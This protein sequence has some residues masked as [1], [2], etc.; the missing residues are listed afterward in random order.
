[1]SAIVLAETKPPMGMVF[2]A[3]DLGEGAIDHLL[4][5][6]PS[7][8]REGV[9]QGWVDAVLR[10]WWTPEFLA[11]VEQGTV[12]EFSKHFRRSGNWTVLS[13]ASAYEDAESAAAALQVYL[14]DYSANWGLTEAG[15]PKLG[16][17][18]SIF[19]GPNPIGGAPMVVYVWRAGPYILHILATG[20]VEADA[21]EIRAIAEGMNDRVPWPR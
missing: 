6:S 8:V 19:E 3:E 10:Q 1:M 5:V 21:D 4:S 17:E 18:G 15:H 11:A 20:S 14:E 12:E 13:G 2:D 9:E 16:D 7:E